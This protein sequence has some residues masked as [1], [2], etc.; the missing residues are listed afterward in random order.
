MENMGQFFRG[1]DNTMVEI[2]I[3]D[4][5]EKI[6]RRRKDGPRPKKKK[7]RPKKM[8]L[9]IQTNASPS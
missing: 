4:V 6:R 2:F 5:V 9:K 7:G 8:K 3:H 1:N